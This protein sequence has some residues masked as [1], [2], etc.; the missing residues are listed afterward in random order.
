MS[1]NIPTL[2]TLDTSPFKRLVLS[3]GAVPS[4]FKDSMTYYELLSWLCNY[5]EKQVLPTINATIEKYDELIIAFNT[6]KD[7][8]DNYFE[9]LDVQEEINNKL[10]EMAESGELG[11]IIAEYFDHAVIV[12]NTLSDLRDDDTLTSEGLTIKT[13]GYYSVND[14]GGAYYVTR[15]KTVSD[16]DDG[17][18]IVFLQND[19]VGVLQ[20]EEGKINIKQFGGVGDGTTDNTDE[21][22]NALDFIKDNLSNHNILYFP[23]GTYK[24]TGDLDDIDFNLSILGESSSNLNKYTN[25][26]TCILDSRAS[27]SPLLNYVQEENVYMQGVSI[28]NI[29]F[30]TEITTAKKCLSFGN[31]GWELILDTVGIEGYKGNAITFTHTNDTVLD[32]CSILACGSYQDSTAYYA[33]EEGGNAHHYTNCHFEHCPYIIH[34]TSTAF[35]NIFTSCKFEQGNGDAYKS[36]E[37]PIL[38]E[39]TQ[40]STF[41]GCNFICPNCYGYYYYQPSLAAASIPF[42]ITDSNDAQTIITGCRIKASSRAGLPDQS[43]YNLPDVR[44]YTGGNLKTFT[45]NVITG[46]SLS[47]PSFS[48]GR[49]TFS[50]NT[51]TGKVRNFNGHSILDGLASYMISATRSTITGNLLWCENPV[52]TKVVPAVYG[53]YNSISN[54]SFYSTNNGTIA[55]NITNNYISRN[56]FAGTE[57]YENYAF[58]SFNFCDPA[59]YDKV[60]IGTNTSISHVPYYSTTI[61]STGAS[62][63]DVVYNAYA[64]FNGKVH[65]KYI[66]NTDAQITVRTAG[67]AQNAGNLI[68]DGKLREFTA[69]T[70]VTNAVKFTIYARGFSGGE[71]ITIIEPW[72]E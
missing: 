9:N 50:G 69:S 44:F 64:S 53:S 60:T 40:G 25:T 21:I 12:R 58:K 57:V 51:M 32:N 15:N 68:G 20:L 4:D 10:D 16:V 49:C 31:L 42:Y 5:L 56:N 63:A 3:F 33:I 38:L 36:S 37:S 55:S 29:E 28:K 52:D 19:L 2:E 43:P 70:A 23:T 39:S 11:R 26:G 22:Q 34:E 35:H 8:V 13:L 59:N 18:S 71:S 7:Y 24:I 41:E 67:G 66:S 14:G 47:V 72:T 65:F 48:V 1:E 45:N 61:T 6:L 54:N 27:T 17:G 46:C 62:D 30:R